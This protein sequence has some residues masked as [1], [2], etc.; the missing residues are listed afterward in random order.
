MD[1]LRDIFGALSVPDF[2][3]AMFRTATPV[4]FATLGAMVSSRSGTSNI[5]LE[6]T[7]LI[8][9]FVGVVVSAFTQSAWVGFL[10]AVLAGFIISNILAYFV[11][12]LKSNA[13]ISGIAINTLASGGTI[14]VLYLITGEKGASTSLH[15]LKLPSIDIPV[16]QDIPIIGQILSGHHVLTYVALILVFAVWYMFK[17]TRLG[18][19]IRAVGESAEAAE[20]VGISVLRVKYIALIISGVLTA[21]GGAFLSM[22]YVGLFSANMTA[23]RGYI[24]LA[25]QAIA[26][27]N[28]VIGMF[29]SLIFGF[30]S[31]LA[32]YLQSS[33]I[34][35]Q[36]IQLMPY[37]IIVIV[38]TCYCAAVERNKLK[39]Q[40]QAHGKKGEEQ[41][42]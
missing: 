24:A 28:A 36:F 8:S 4:L 30:C 5:A 25:T 33:G 41:T 35:L 26:A 31:S 6:G 42:K 22:G 38:Y 10:G 32:N 17:Y 7:M 11:L 16:I 20:S 3:F 14:F 27:G 39:R 19:H 23:G 18:M 9:A 21:M 2:Y 1:I 34:P 37:I 29:A 12:K 40:M 15:S 13:V